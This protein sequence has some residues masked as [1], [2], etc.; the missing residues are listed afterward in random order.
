MSIPDALRDRSSRME[1]AEAWKNR[2]A[3]LRDAARTTRD[4]LEQQTLV[5]LAEDCDEIAKRQ[6]ATDEETG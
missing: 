2:A 5:L 1:N 3:R 4:Q 6:Q